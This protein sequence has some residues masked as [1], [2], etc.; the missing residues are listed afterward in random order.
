MI[1]EKI[2]FQNKKSKKIYFNYLPTKKKK[3]DKNK[4]IISNKKSKIKIRLNYKYKKKL[5]NK[6]HNLND[7]N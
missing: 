7:F 6:V 2:L 1:K 5:Q 4:N 3:N